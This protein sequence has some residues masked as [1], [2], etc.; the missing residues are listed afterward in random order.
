M[1]CGMG[2][3]DARTHTDTPQNKKVRECYVLLTRTDRISSR[4]V[5]SPVYLSLLYTYDDLLFWQQQQQQQEHAC[6]RT[7]VTAGRQALLVDL[8]LH[9]TKVVSTYRER[10]AYFFC[11]GPPYEGSSL[12]TVVSTSLQFYAS[13]QKQYCP[14][15]API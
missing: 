7:Y 2:A 9:N 11:H 10:V 1:G 3:Q 4:N 14:S 13:Q 6:V 15:S 8:L 5:F 12:R